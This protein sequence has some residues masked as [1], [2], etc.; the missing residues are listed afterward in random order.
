MKTSLITIV[1]LFLIAILLGPA[2]SQS[3]PG[4]CSGWKNT[5]IARCAGVAN[6]NCVKNCTNRAA[7]CRSTGCFYAAAESRDYCGLVKK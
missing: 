3:V 2:R 6:P 1:A 5:C 4:T 7:T